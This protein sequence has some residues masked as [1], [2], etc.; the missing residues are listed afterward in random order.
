VGQDAD[1]GDDRH[2]RLAR[3]E[4]GGTREDAGVKGRDEVGTGAHAAP[5]H[6]CDDR[7]RAVGDKTDGRLEPQQVEEELDEP[8]V[9]Q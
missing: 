7:H 6:R 8:L 5:V 2:L 4:D 3:R 9:A 1:V